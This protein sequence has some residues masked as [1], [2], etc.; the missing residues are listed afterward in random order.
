MSPEIWSSPRK[1]NQ[2]LRR[3]FNLCPHATCFTPLLSYLTVLPWRKRRLVTSK[4]RLSPTTALH[5]R[6]EI[7]LCLWAVHS[8]CFRNALRER[9]LANIRV[10]NSPSGF[11]SWALYGR[12]NEY[13]YE[14]R[15]GLSWPYR[16]QYYI[17][18][19]TFNGDQYHIS[20]ESIVSETLH[21]L[22]WQICRD[23]NSSSLRKMLSSGIWRRVGLV[24][25]HVSEE[26]VA[27][28]IRVARIGELGSTLKVVKKC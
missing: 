3:A 20:T 18:S 19:T 9:T 6:R 4:V 22:H 13:R 8:L 16:K 23:D 12:A 26:I 25:T 7:C 21:F 28:I 1:S 11:G 24:R 10:V 14:L 5:P 17:T 2:H 27:S 15:V